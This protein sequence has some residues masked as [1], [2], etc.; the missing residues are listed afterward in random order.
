MWVCDA[1]VQSVAY[2]F[3]S[4]KIVTTAID[5]EMNDRFHIIPG[6]GERSC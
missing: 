5:E 1:G 2:A 6:I 3:P 4:V